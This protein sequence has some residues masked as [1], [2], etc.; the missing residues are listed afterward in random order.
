MTNN[1]NGFASRV[2]A[3][4]TLR[5]PFL[6]CCIF[7]FFFAF[8]AFLRICVF[9]LHTVNTSIEIHCSN[10]CS[11]DNLCSLLAA[12]ASVPRFSGELA[13]FAIDIRSSRWH[14]F[15]RLLSDCQQRPSACGELLLFSLA[16]AVFA[17]SARLYILRF[18][19]LLLSPVH[20]PLGLLRR[21]EG[22]TRKSF[23]KGEKMCFR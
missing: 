8:F 1:S 17:V 9:A 20:F 2:L 16:V 19:S 13:R 22:K 23:K 6:R 11:V 21:K 10:L 12:F 3:F 4:C 5:C 7:A 14:L 15:P 18:L